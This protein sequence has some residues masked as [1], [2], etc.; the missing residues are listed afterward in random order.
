MLEIAAASPMS[1]RPP[2]SAETDALYDRMARAVRFLAANR[3]RQPDLAEAASVTGL[4]PTH[5]QRVFTRYVGLSPKRFVGYLTLEAAKGAL[6]EAEP[7]LEAAFT[8]GLSGPGRLHDLFVTYEAMTPGE[9]KAKGAGLDLAYG[10]AATPFGSLLCISSPR[11]IVGLAF[12]DAEARVGAAP[13]PT[14]KAGLDLW[15]KDAAL[16]DMRARWPLARV[17]ADDAPAQAVAAAIFGAARRAPIRLFLSGTNFQVRVWEALLELQPG[18][19]TTYS[20]LAAKL[21]DPA[22]TRAVA[23]A[24]GRNPISL[25]IP[26]HRVLRADGGLG[27]YHWGLTRKRALLA[28]ERGT[29]RAA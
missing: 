26:C 3:E 6:E 10:F 23:S 11:G 5:F 19:T 25:L 8:A 2:Q 27:G 20:A 29:G 4:S 7:V 22:A 14:A 28:W 17:H 12:A 16:A 24:V 9:F 1:R 21:K 15:A 18:M 13:A